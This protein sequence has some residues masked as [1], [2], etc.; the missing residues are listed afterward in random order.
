MRFLP[1]LIQSTDLDKTLDFS[2]GQA[3][4]L[5]AALVQ[6]RQALAAAT[7]ASTMPTSTIPQAALYSQLMSQ[8]NGGMGM[9]SP[10]MARMMQ[11]QATMGPM[12]PVD[13]MRGQQ[14]AAVG[15]LSP[16]GTMSYSGGARKVDSRDMPQVSQKGS[17]SQLLSENMNR[18]VPSVPWPGML[19]GQ[20][21]G[22]ASSNSPQASSMYGQVNAPNTSSGRNTASNYPYY[23]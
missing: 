6:R 23:Q 21:E 22:G 20:M 7:G 14:A 16:G 17:Y 2:T 10:G 8:V 12:S 5:L 4:S 18:S 1:Y 11:Q 3:G 15:D 9:V 13:V 19:S